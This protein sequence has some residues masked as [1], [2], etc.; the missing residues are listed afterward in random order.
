MTKTASLKA[1]PRG[2]VGKESARKLR[3]GDRVPAILYGKGMD[4]RPLSLDRHEVEHLFQH[5][6]VENTILTLH[7]EGDPEPVEALVREI[8]T[9]PHKTGL[10]HVDF[11]RIQRGVAVE[12]EVPVRLEG[13][14][15]GVREAGGILEQLLDDLRIRCL[16]TQ[17]PDAVTVDV[18]GLGVGEALHV[19]DLVLEPGIT[20][21]SDPSLTVC[22]VLAPRV[23]VEAAEVRAEEEKGEGGA[24][25]PEGREGTERGS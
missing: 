19:S 7:I 17:I 16:P 6:S 8:Q 9:Y 23:P 1:R 15:R 2:Q 21:L 13:I 4:P 22:T 12:V 3:A 11:L 25:G 10:L 18:T 20:L 24:A 5:I 14:P